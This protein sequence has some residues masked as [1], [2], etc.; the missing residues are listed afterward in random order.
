MPQTFTMYFLRLWVGGLYRPFTLRRKKMSEKLRRHLG[1]AKPTK[2]DS[3]GRVQ[4][5]S[6]LRLTQPAGCNMIVVLM[7]MFLGD[8]SAFAHVSPRHYPKPLAKKIA[9]VVHQQKMVLDAACMPLAPPNV[10]QEETG[11]LHSI[12]TGL[13]MLPRW[14]VAHAYRFVPSKV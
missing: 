13:L 7:C 2:R 10:A 6:S 3:D 12:A 8:Y 14:L 5:T 1:V 4:G 9:K 11:C